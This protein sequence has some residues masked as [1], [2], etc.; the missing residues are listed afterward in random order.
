MKLEVGQTSLFLGRP[1]RRDGLGDNVHH[2]LLAELAALEAVGLRVGPALKLGWAQRRR[3]A[4]PCLAACCAFA[5]TDQPIASF[6]PKGRDDFRCHPSL[7]ARFGIPSRLVDAKA[8]TETRPGAGPTQ[9]PT[10]AMLASIR[11]SNANGC[12]PLAVR[13]VSAQAN[14]MSAGG[15]MGVRDS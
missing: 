14:T 12:R 3:K 2:D 10:D 7:A 15:P 4:Q 1:G 5:S 8:G 6:N 11:Q 9:S 13:H